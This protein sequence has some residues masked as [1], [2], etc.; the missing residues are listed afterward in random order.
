MFKLVP[1]MGSEEEAK[2]LP[3][4]LETLTFFPILGCLADLV[5]LNDVDFRAPIPRLFRVREFETKL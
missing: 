4:D 1:V 3:C 2:Y 5:T